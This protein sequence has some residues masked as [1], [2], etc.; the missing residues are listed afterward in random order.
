MPYCR[1]YFPYDIKECLDGFGP[2]V[3]F[4][5]DVTIL[6]PGFKILMNT[7]TV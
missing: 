7:G 1:H 3:L 5:L 4:I 2:R 6:G